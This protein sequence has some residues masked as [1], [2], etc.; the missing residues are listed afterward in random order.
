M[1]SLK[2][3]CR[4]EGKDDLIAEL[5]EAGTTGIVEEEF[6]G[7]DCLLEAFFDTEAEAHVAAARFAMHNP[8]WIEHGQRD[9]VAQFQSQW[10][11]QPVGKRFWLAAPWDESAAPAGRIRIEYQAGMACGSGVHPCTRLCLAALEDCVT[12]GASVLDVGAGSGILLMACRALGAARLYGCDIDHDS[13]VLAARA[14]PDALL[15]TGSLRA[16]RDARFDVVI[17]NISSIAAE[18]M[19][20]ELRRVCR[21]GGTVLVS[22]FRSGDWPQGYDGGTRSEQ[23][24]WAA[25]TIQSPR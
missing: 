1:I 15:F 12:P 8:Q 19:L 4:I 21:P 24:G 6:L 17:A 7:G 10:Q 20:G 2:L 16:V 9:Y 14:Q 23:E 25:I 22:G 3:S 13:T 18:E 11:P 5:Y